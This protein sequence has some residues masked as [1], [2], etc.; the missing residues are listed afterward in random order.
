MDPSDFQTT[1]SGALFVMPRTS[2]AWQS[3]RGLWITVAGWAAAAQ[4]V[5]G[6]SWVVTPDRVAGAREV[7]EWMR[8]SEPKPGTAPNP[9]RRAVPA[10]LV[11]AAKD[12]R[13]FRESRHF[14]D[15][16][17]AGPWNGHELAFVWQQ[18]DLFARAGGRFARRNGVPLVLY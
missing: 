8:S 4:H 14:P 10:P 18:H 11:T 15:L 17:D 2:A 7:L 6:A 1:S 13:L 9:L 3:A 12:V 5:L 16:D